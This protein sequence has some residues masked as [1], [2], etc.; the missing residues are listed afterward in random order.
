[1]PIGTDPPA[2]AAASIEERASQCVLK[3]K[4]LCLYLEHNTSTM[5][6]RVNAY[7]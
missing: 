4:V 2:A 3:Y 5:Y 7:L 6:I 1:M